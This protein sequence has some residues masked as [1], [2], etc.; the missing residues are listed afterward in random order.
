MRNLMSVLLMLSL[1]LNLGIAGEEKKDVR[2]VEISGMHC[3]NCAA[4]VE[5]ALKSLNGV[6]KVSVDRDKGEA[7]V[8]VKAKTSVKTADLVKAVAAVGYTAKSG[9]V[10]LEPTEKCDDDCDDSDHANHDEKTKEGAEA[11]AD[12]CTVKPKS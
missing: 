7:L 9:K 1:A 8:T 6:E 12:C 3:D 5:T 4:K 10:E 11:K 2:R